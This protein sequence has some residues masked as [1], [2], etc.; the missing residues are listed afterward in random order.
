MINDPDW[1]GALPYTI[2]I[3]PGGKVLYKTQ[4]AID[5][6]EVRTAITDYLGHFYADNK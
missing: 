3:A 2:L 4:G 5:P 1:G 6:L